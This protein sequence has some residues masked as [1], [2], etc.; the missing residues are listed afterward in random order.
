MRV[1]VLFLLGVLAWDKQII[2]RT[3]VSSCMARRR[4]LSNFHYCD[5]GKLHYMGNLCAE[6]S[7]EMSSRLREE[8]RVE[9]K[10][11]ENKADADS[12]NSGKPN[13]AR[14]A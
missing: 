8:W 10:K 7:E 9:Q 14:S 2:P 12:S 13:G 4:L 11:K 1:Q 5:Y 6:C 3:T